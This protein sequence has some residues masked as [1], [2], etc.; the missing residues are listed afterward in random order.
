V[1]VRLPVT[2][3]AT[4]APGAATGSVQFQIDSTA[5]GDPVA[6]TAGTAS[7]SDGALSSSTHTVTVRYIPDNGC[8]LTSTSAGFKQRVR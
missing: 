7:I 4:V 1:I 2:L 6:L 5:F 3:Y 8:F